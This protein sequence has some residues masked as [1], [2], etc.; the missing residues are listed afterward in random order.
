MA[1]KFTSLDEISQAFGFGSVTPDDLRDRLKRR[2]S[3]L[4]PDHT[5]GQF[6]TREQEDEFHRVE[7]ALRSAEGIVS[8]GNSL[9]PV[10]AIT[11]IVRAIKEAG[12]PAA[13]ESREQL[14]DSRLGGHI[15]R[16]LGAFRSPLGAPAAALGAVTAAL[17]GLWLFP[18]VVSEHPVLS[19][20]IDPSSPF[21][22]AV[23]FYLLVN[24][25]VVWL[26]SWRQKDRFEHLQ[27]ALR[28]DAYQNDLFEQFVREMTP[29]TEFTKNDFVTFIRERHGDRY[30]PALV[31][32]L[33]DASI[34][35]ETSQ[36]VAELVLLRLEQRGVISQLPGKTLSPKYRLETD[37]R[38]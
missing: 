16:N 3:E 34:D 18:G 12:V 27:R 17:M 25:A 33:R 4:H 35:A 10:E 37:L 24:A 13:R 38:E 32:M 36:T 5:G 29:T 6:A 1:T 23:W 11:E 9:V 7:Q 30:R 14:L 20:Y 31:Q 26:M 21:F 8:V 2:R 22:G 15:D 19:R 28:T